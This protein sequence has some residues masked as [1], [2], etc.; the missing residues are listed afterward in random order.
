M[1]PLSLLAMVLIGHI[2]CMVFKVPAIANWL[3]TCLR[4]LK[5]VLQNLFLEKN[6]LPLL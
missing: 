5:Q 4:Q 6:P 2:I 3:G 1:L